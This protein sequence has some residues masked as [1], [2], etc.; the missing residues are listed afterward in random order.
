MTDTITALSAWYREQCDGDW[1]H[2]HGV[3][4]TTLDN[5]G[6]WVKVDL[7]GTALAEAIYADV[8]EGVDAGG[9]PRAECWLRCRIVDGQWHGAGDPARLDDIIRHFLTWART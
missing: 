2:H 7:A 1:E 6:W 9:H 8:A 5:P 4:I 3:T